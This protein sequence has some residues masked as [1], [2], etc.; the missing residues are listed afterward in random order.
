MDLSADS[1]FRIPASYKGYVTG[2]D[3]RENEVAFICYVVVIILYIF[4]V[5]FSQWWLLLVTSV[6]NLLIFFGVVVTLIAV[7]LFEIFTVLS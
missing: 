3:G 2:N 5:L 4:F 1:R 6:S 7:I